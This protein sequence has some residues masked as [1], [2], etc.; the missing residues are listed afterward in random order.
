[1]CRSR[2][3]YERIALYVENSHVRLIPFRAVPHIHPTLALSM[4]LGCR[5]GSPL[6]LLHD[7]R[8]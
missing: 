3:I 5:Y 4:P 1:M 7:D 2:L 8:H 6:C